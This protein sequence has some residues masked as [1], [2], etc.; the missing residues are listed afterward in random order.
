MN[1]AYEQIRRQSLDWVRQAGLIAQERF[2]TAVTSRKPD[3][4]PVTD[5]DLAVQ[6]ALL[7]AIAQHYPNDA[8][9]TEETQADPGKHATIASAQRCWVIDPIDGTR[10]YARSVPL[11]CVSVAM[12][13]NGWPVVG[14]IY[15]P[16]TDRM[17]S[18]SAGGGLWLNE[19]RLALDS[20]SHSLDVLIGTPSGQRHQLPPAVHVWLDKY[21]LRNTGSTALHLAHLATGGFDA[22]LVTESHLWDIAAGFL[23]GQEAGVIT[24]CLDGSDL[25]PIALAAGAK[26]EFTFLSAS[27]DKF[28]TLWNDLP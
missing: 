6:E 5:V 23:L 4:S 25:F 16:M 15:N 7:D 19:D 27:V 22:V 10:N 21:K 17:Y 2:G 18:A 20:A 3:D 24:Q 9:I 12:M 8:V 26:R 1:E 28:Q 11:F 13:E 14:M